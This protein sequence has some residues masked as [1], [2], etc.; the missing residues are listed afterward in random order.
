ME[1]CVRLV[2]LENGCVIA[3]DVPKNIQSNKAVIEAYLG[4]DE[5]SW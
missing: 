2:R 5:G 1:V 4:V 3:G